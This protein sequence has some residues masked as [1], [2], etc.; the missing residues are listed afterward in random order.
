MKIPTY[1]LFTRQFLY[2]CAALAVVLYFFYFCLWLGFMQKPKRKTSKSQ[3]AKPIHFQG[4]IKPQMS[5]NK[6]PPPPQKKKKKYQKRLKKKK[7]KKRLEVRKVM[8][9]HSE[10]SFCSSAQ[11]T[12]RRERRAEKGD[13]RGRGG[14]G[15]GVF[16]V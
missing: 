13:V 15:G 2:I 8:S 10:G 1:C 7:K 16:P 12:T 4:K 6:S 14:R 9:S 3:N 11:G 5:W